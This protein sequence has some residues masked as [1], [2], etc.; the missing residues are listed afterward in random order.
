[1]LF[2]VYKNEGGK[3]AFEVN[4]RRVIVATG[5]KEFGRALGLSDF[6]LAKAII[7]QHF[8]IPC[9]SLNFIDG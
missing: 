4:K 8:A 9:G 5:G 2:T 7:T 6:R 1:M 3:Q